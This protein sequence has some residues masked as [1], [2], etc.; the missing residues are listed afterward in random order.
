MIN[1]NI[2]SLTFNISLIPFVGHPYVRVREFSHQAEVI[3]ADIINLQEVHSYDMVWRLKQLTEF[4]YVSYKRGLLGPIAGLVT[5]SK[6]FIIT[7]SFESLSFHKGVIVSRLKSGVV[8][9]NVHLVANT[10]GD[11]SKS[12]RFYDKH[13][14]QLDKLNEIMDRF[15]YK[16]QPI[17]LSGDFNLAKTSDLYGYFI[18]KGGW[19]DTTPS[20]FEPTFHSDFLPPD[21]NPQR[22]DY[23]LVRGNFQF[24]KTALLFG[25]KINGLYLSNHLGVFAELKRPK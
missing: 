14:A 19:H 23:I 20:D 10:D 18:R 7:D 8:V 15:T 2:K 22:V 12:N 5:F 9:V 25:S 3:N 17:I 21:R 16:N 11:W 4:P 6:Q 13:K 24:L 1:N